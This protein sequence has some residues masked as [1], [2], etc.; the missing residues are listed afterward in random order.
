V[1]AA[2]VPTAHEEHSRAPWRTISA[3]PRDKSQTQAAD[4]LCPGCAVIPPVEDRKTA[5]DAHA[6][7]PGASL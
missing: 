1:S 7:A 5:H 3:N 6:V 2:Y 4:E